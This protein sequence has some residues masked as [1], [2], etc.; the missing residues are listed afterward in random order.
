MDSKM[1]PFGEPWGGKNAQNLVF[2]RSWFQAIFGTDSE[3]LLGRLRRV[4]TPGGRVPPQWDGV[5]EWPVLVY[6]PFKVN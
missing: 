6:F 5:G 4:V 3:W 1:T 2:L